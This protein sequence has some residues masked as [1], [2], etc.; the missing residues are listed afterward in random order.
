MKNRKKLRLPYYDYKTPGWYFVTICTQNHEWYFG[1]IIKN[2]MEL[3]DIGELVRNYW[4]KISE[5]NEN[6]A[7]DE[8]VVMPNHL[9]GIVIIKDD[10]QIP[11]V[12]E[13]YFNNLSKIENTFHVD[14]FV[15]VGHARPLQIENFE[16]KQHKDNLSTILGGFKSAMTKT[17]NEAACSGRACPSTTSH[18]ITNPSTTNF[19]WHRSFHDIII[20]DEDSL[21]NIWDYIFENPLNWEN[22]IEFL[23]VSDKKEIENYYRSIF[24]YESI[25]K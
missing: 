4:F 7:L 20:R 8:F 24:K 12:G 1:E 5:H 9:H 3:S 15:G 25:L 13:G 10:G 17:V 11:Q 14:Q 19:G 6:I 23:K 2:E 18:T 16:W 22:D 21:Q